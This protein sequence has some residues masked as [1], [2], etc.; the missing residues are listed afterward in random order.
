MSWVSASEAARHWGLTSYR[1]VHKRSK[2]DPKTY[3]SR[4]HPTRKGWRQY[5]IGDGPPPG[6]HREDLG[7]QLD[8]PPALKHSPVE[9]WVEREGYVYDGRRDMYILTLPSHRRPFVLDGARLRQIWRRYAGDKAN[10]DEICRDFGFDRQTFLDLKRALAL[11][12]TRAPF[13]DEELDALGEEDL[14]ADVLRAKEQRVM[15]RAQ[16]SNWRRIE[17]LAHNRQWLRE[18]VRAALTDLVG[19]VELP[20]P[21]GEPEEVAVVVGWSDLHVGKRAAGSSVGLD[22]QLARL[23]ALAADV[24]ARVAA[25]SPSRVIVACTGDLVHSDTQS[26]TTTKGTPQGPQSEGSTS[27]AL[28]GACE[29]TAGLIFKLSEVAPTVEV[30]V[31]PGNHDELLSRAVGFYLEAAFDGSSRVIIDADERRR[32]KWSRWREVPIC[33]FHGDKL[34]GDRLAALPGRECPVGADPRR[35]VLFH[36]HYHKRALRQDV[37]GGFDVVCLASPAGPDDWHHEHGFEGGAKAITLAVIAPSGL[38]A[39]EW[40]RA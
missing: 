23:R 29:L 11:T 17:R 36:G 5:W 14:V 12:K 10:V 15:A 35:A 33:F 39:L 25:L 30:V 24:V 19:P 31:V 6:A 28:R 1:G 32:R 26:Q 4:P 8:A 37:V 38:T 40:V 27:M 9:G 22:V 16:A 13:T 18:T 3:P 21:V 20:P 7:D 2:R 34:K